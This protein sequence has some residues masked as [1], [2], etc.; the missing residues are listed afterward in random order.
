MNLEEYLT[1]ELLEDF[2]GRGK[3]FSYELAWY[4]AKVKDYNGYIEMFQG[5][6]DLLEWCKKNYELSDRFIQLTLAMLNE[7]S[8]DPLLPSGKVGILERV[9]ELKRIAPRTPEQ[10]QKNPER[11]A[12]EFWLRRLEEV[13]AVSYFGESGLY[14]VSK[15]AEMA[16]V[17]ESFVEEVN[18][19]RAFVHEKKEKE[20]HAA[21]KD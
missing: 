12:R 7:K 16:E 9:A 13:E 4:L 2:A 14:T 18:M 1:E 21:A 6:P 19:I 11:Y 10:I 8:D 20:K 15:I 3:K 17:S 5:N